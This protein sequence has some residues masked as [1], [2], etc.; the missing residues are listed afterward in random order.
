MNILDLPEEV[1]TKKCNIYIYI[2]FHYAQSIIYIYMREFEQVR[3]PT[4][5]T[6]IGQMIN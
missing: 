4:F 2:L 5:G 1:L 6:Q 3:C